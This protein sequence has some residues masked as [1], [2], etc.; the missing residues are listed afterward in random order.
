MPLVQIPEPPPSEPRLLVTDTLEA[1]RVLDT[2]KI[3]TLHL[4]SLQFVQSVV[5]ADKHLADD[6]TA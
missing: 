3:R 1:R 6:W 2:L 5:L 4:L